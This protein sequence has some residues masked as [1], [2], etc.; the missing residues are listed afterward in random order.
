MGGKEGKLR[1]KS[2]YER[3]SIS[4]GFNLG[5]FFFFLFKGLLSD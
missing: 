2:K 4:G 3:I 1:R 5:F